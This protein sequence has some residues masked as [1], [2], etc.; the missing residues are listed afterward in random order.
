MGGEAA[1]K[2]RL[3]PERIL[4]FDIFAIKKHTPNLRLSNEIAQEYTKSL[5]NKGERFRSPSN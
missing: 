4:P 3:E 2:T 5:I 1:S